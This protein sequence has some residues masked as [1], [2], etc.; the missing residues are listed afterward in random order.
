MKRHPFD[1]L[2]FVF[3]AL[4]LLLGLLVIAGD[5]TRLLSAWLA[6]AAIIGLGMLLLFVGWQSTRASGEETP[7][8]Q[9]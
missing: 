4:F 9:A 7:G 2:S 1:A 3:G 5:A 6:P 8:D